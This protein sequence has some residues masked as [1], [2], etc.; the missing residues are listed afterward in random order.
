MTNAD[1]VKLG[2]EFARQMK[3]FITRSKYIAEPCLDEILYY[4]SKY[5]LST[6][7]ADC[8]TYEDECELSKIA[9]H[10][11]D[12]PT[13]DPTITECGDQATITLSKSSTACTY[14][15]SLENL[16]GI[17]SAFPTLV[18]EEDT[19]YQAAQIKVKA[20]GCGDIA[21]DT[22]I[23]GCKNITNGSSPV[24]AETYKFSLN[25]YYNIEGPHKNTT[26]YIKTI[27]LYATDSNG[28]LINTP[29]DVDVSPSNLATWTGCGLCS[30]INPTD[31]Y[32]GSANWASAFKELLDNVIYTLNGALDALWLVSSG[33]A[34][35][36]IGNT[37]KN[38]PASEWYGINKN[39]FRVQWVN[40]LA[41]VITV[42]SPNSTGY[43]ITQS[44]MADEFTITTDCGDLTGRAVMNA[45]K[46]AYSA[47]SNFNELITTNLELDKAVSIVN[48]D[49]P[50]CTITTLTA[51]FTSSVSDPI[52]YWTNSDDDVIS[53]ELTVTVTEAGEYTFTVV[54][55]EGCVSQN[56]ITV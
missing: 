10:I 38:A 36:S 35:I 26:G 54:V 4:F 45:G 41:A 12:E 7:L 9:S 14:T 16:A 43:T 20:T 46:P 22:V 30:G 44:Y 23:T 39:D 11:A 27:R 29:I 40:D 24:C 2:C 1:V 52:Y 5:K 34:Y 33:P 49:S 13:V 55:G 42:T 51:S 3:L 6:T 28:V 21:Y 50:S 56:S 25:I 17:A 19:V 8:L 37:V 53:D 47:M 31:L 32:F 48:L 18:L 15:V